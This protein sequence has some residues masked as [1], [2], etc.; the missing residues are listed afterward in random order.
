M[1][2]VQLSKKT[3]SNLKLHWSSSGHRYCTK[4]EEVITGTP[5]SKLTIGVP[6]EIFKNEKRVALTP[7]SVAALIKQGFNVNIEES[8]GFE[9]KF[10]NDQYAESGAKIV[11]R[12]KAFNT[13]L[14]L[15]VR[16]PASDE[17]A[18]LQARTNLISF[19]YPAQ[20][21]Q[22]IDEL[23]KK[24]MTV[25]AMDAIPRVSRAQVFDALSSMANIAGY[26]AVVEAANNFGR[27]FTGTVRN[28]VIPIYLQCIAITLCY[29]SIFNI[30]LNCIA[31]ISYCMLKVKAAALSPNHAFSV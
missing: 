18:Q 5:Y 14:V 29:S 23:A 16:A 4:A 24:D 22:L 11:D 30:S 19:L 8:A 26:K 10:L 3:F 1:K 9:A 31:L 6:K 17:I 12:Q 28:L 13:D 7:T 20:N 21:K 15:K 27:F 2:F 25:F